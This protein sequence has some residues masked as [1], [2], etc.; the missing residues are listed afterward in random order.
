MPRL[1]GFEDQ[2]LT[3]VKDSERQAV[4]EVVSRLRAGMTQPQAVAWLNDSG[5][6]GTMG[7]E[8][9]TM[10]LGR[11]LAN[12]AIAGLAVDPKTK[13]LYETG[14]PGL[15]PREDFE[16]LQQRPGRRRNG[17]APVEEDYSYWLSNGLAVCGPCGQSLVGAR[18]SNGKPSYRCAAKFEHKVGCG[19]IR[20]NAAALEDY[21]GEYLLGEL[22]RPGAVEALRTAQE[23]F[24]EKA[25]RVTTQIGLLE[26]RRTEL[27]VAYG[28]GDLSMTTLAAAE[29]TVIQNL[30]EARHRLRLI[31]QAANTRLPRT[32]AIRDLVKWW[33]HAPSAVKWGL[34]VLLL[35]KVAV[36]P[37]QARGVRA[38]DGRVDVVF[39]RT[40]LSAVA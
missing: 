2:A 26:H 32:D 23:E 21:V 20:I 36:R 13:E 30:R 39:R 29:R 7:G 1:F 10:T 34:A 6:R 12:P 33:G 37:A 28:N 4:R 22:A 11:L 31:E 19:T 18:S 24:K 15:I 8:W 5:Y 27:G 35:E 17:Q 3:R 38:V 40:S 16:W 14:R 9:T 25:K